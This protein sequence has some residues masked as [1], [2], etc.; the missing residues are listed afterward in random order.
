MNWIDYIIIS[1]V[2]ISTIFGVT[3]GFTSEV[4]Y[5]CSWIGS[6]I[7]TIKYYS[8]LS[9]IIN[10]QDTFICNSVSIFAIFISSLIAGNII[11][12]YMSKLIQKIGLSWIDKLLGAYF[13][14][15]RGILIVATLFLFLDA[16]A[17]IGQKHNFQES[18]FVPYLNKIIEYCY[19]YFNR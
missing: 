15:L 11:N 18:K 14:V 19:N 2:V 6:I 10:I 9:K 8:P 5:L 3:S 17:N 16:F 4:L 1:I 12:Y 7:L 13:G